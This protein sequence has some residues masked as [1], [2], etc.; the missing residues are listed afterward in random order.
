MHCVAN[1]VIEV[2]ILVFKFTAE[3]IRVSF[4]WVL[5]PVDARN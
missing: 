1:H 5:S 3:E 2:C 4:F